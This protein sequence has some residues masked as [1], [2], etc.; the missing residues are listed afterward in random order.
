MRLVALDIDGTILNSKGELTPNVTKEIQRCMDDPELQV[1]FCSGR[2]L[3]GI[4]RLF[5]TLQTSGEQAHVLYNGA[6]IQKETGEKLYEKTISGHQFIEVQQY[7]EQEHLTL[8]AVKEDSVISITNKLN[9]SAIKFCYLTESD[10]WFRRIEECRCDQYLKL[11]IC[12]KEQIINNI[13]GNINQQFSNQFYCIQG[14]EEFIE[15]APS[16]V[17]KGKTLAKLVEYYN[18]DKEDVYVVGDNENDLSMFELF[19]NSIAMGNA[20]V[21]LKQKAK[22]VCASNDEDGVVDVLKNIRKYIW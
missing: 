9:S 6:C 21:E 10:I 11:M 16:G 19:S 13:K 7:C 5:K 15:L 3:A 8:V 17:N 4:K 14:H 1:V 20:V 12:E 22:R 18:I 2:N